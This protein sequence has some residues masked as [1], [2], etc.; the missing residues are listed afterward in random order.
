[1]TRAELR[2][3]AFVALECVLLGA[4]AEGFLAWSRLD[5]RLLAPV[6]Y[7]QGADRPLHRL[8]ADAALHYE[9]VPGSSAVFG[10]RR[11]TINALGFRGPERSAR[12]PAGVFRIVCLGASNAYGAAVGDDETYPALLERELNGP[13]GTRYEVWNAG[14]SAYVLAQNAAAAR[15]IVER[16]SP[17][18]LIFQTANFGRRTFLAGQ[19]FERYFEEDPGLYAEN[20]PYPAAIRGTRWHAALMRRWRLYRALVIAYNRLRL[21]RSQNEGAW[22]PVLP[23]NDRYNAEAF[24]EFLRRLRGRVP[25]ALLLRAGVAAGERDERL[26]S[27]GLP[28]LD[29][30]TMLPAGADPA[31]REIHPPARVYAWYARALAAFLRRERLVP[32]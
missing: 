19:P 1:M 11:V 9:L 22:D 10:T 18:L 15:A 2:L 16:F 12:K 29:L 23:E 31:Y 8:S 27:A 5:A 13:R 7:Y 30:E 25:V 26:E 20:L 4:A 14:V 32:R 24:A 21:P 28:F 6:L 3:A 17:D